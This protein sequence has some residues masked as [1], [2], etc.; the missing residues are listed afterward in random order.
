MKEGCN[1]GNGHRKRHAGAT[2]SQ[3]PRGASTAPG[4]GRE[5]MRTAFLVLTVPMCVALCLGGCA[6][7]GEAPTDEELVM[8]QTHRFVD[9]FLAADVD[10]ILSY[11]SEDFSAQRVESKQALEAYIE[12]GRAS[13]RLDDMEAMIEQYDARIE[14]Q[15]AKV[16]I[17]GNKAYVYPIDASASVGAVSAEL[18]FTKDPDGVWR[19]SGLNVDGM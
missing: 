13:G 12:M 11:V 16:T 17:D 6:R 15:D 10:N 9:D 2:V 3:D 7:F 8:Q 14:L 19:I 18:E 5:E 4:N 1:Q